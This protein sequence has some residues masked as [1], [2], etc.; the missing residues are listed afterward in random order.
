MNHII[1]R[2]IRHILRQS[3]AGIRIELPAGIILLLLLTGCASL[4][5]N[6]HRSKSFAYTET[7]NTRYGMAQ[8]HEKRAHPGKSGFLLLADGLDAYVA[9]TILARGA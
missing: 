1:K 8:L 4:P 5:D 6:S 2:F 9:R 3:N 7:Q